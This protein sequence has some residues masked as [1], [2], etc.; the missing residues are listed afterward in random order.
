M[1][2]GMA[3]SPCW[4]L[5]V[6]Q[7][8]SSTRLPPGRDSANGLR[9]AC[10]LF[11]CTFSVLRLRLRYSIKVSQSVMEGICTT[12][13]WSTCQ[14]LTKWC[15][16]LALITQMLLL[17]DN[18]F[19]WVG[20]LYSYIFFAH[21]HPLLPHEK[22]YAEYLDTQKKYERDEIFVIYLLEIHFVVFKQ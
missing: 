14:G 3:A 13:L 22:N 8:K 19:E 5:N 6:S 18:L 1:T 9:M 10:V 17:L 15:H 21:Q 12:N 11:H 2:I 4:C 7:Q 20:Q 16:A